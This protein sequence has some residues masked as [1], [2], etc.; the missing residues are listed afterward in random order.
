[1]S[2][3]QTEI[4]DAIGIDNFSGDVILTMTDHLK[5]G[6]H[7]HLLML[8]EKLNTYLRF[9]ESGEILEI[10]PDAK[11]RNVLISLQCQYPP[12]KNGVKF[13]NQVSGFIKGAGINFSVSVA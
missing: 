4:I 5:W 10:F 2:I 3:D 6:A 1:M 9:V 13:L 12:D 11:E 8:Q 7:H